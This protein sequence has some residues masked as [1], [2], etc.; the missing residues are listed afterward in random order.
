MIFYKITKIT[1]SGIYNHKNE[2]IGYYESLYDSINFIKMEVLKLFNKKIN[3]ENY[4]VK[5]EV[6]N[7]YIEENRENNL[8]YKNI[9]TYK[10]KY[11]DDYEK[12]ITFLITE[13]NLEE[14]KE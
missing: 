12:V 3:N 4:E 10:Y 11:P 9:T 13:E 5:N 8:C 6:N 1:Q 2:T 14:R 7:Y